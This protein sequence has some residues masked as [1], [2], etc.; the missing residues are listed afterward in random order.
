[1]FSLS[2]IAGHVFIIST[3]FS[4]KN[5]LFLAYTHQTTLLFSIVGREGLTDEKPEYSN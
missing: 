2:A 5:S 4:A 1:M 3:H